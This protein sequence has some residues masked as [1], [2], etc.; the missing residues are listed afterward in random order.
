MSELDEI[1]GASAGIRELRRRIEELL[2]RQAHTPGQT[3]PP[4]LLPILIQGETGTGKTMLAQII[5]Q[6]GPRRASRFVDVDCGTIPADLLEAEL[7]GHQ[8]GS[9]TGA[10]RSRTGLFQTAHGGTLFLDEIGAL[11]LALQ[12]K[13]LKAIADRE[14][15]PVG[16]RRSEPADVAI[17]AATNDNLAVAARQG[18]FRLDLYHRLAGV[19][20]TL[21]PL[22]D[23]GADIITL[24]ERFLARACTTHGLPAKTLGE[25]ARAALCAYAWPGNIRELGYVMDR[26]AL[27]SDATTVTADALG[28]PMGE[29][30]AATSEAMCAR[31]LDA[32][33]R[34]SWNIT[35]TAAL[36]G[37]TRLTVRA[38]IKRCGLRPEGGIATAPALVTDTPTAEDAGET[39]MAPPAAVEPSAPSP[40]SAGATR[41]ERRRVTLLRVRLRASDDTSLSTTAR[42]IEGLFERVRVFGGQVED[43]SPRGFLA[44]FGLDPDE[45]APRRAAETALALRGGLRT[46]RTGE[47][48]PTEIAVV[49]AIHVSAMLV[50][51]LGGA[52]AIDGDAKLEAGRMLETLERSVGPGEIALSD[53]AVAFLDRRFEVTREA[54]AEG[55]IARL[56]GRAPD[57]LRLATTE[58]VGRHRELALLHGLLEHAVSGRGQIVSIVGAPGIGKSRLVREFVRSLTPTA[59]GVL[60]GR[61]T[62]LNASVPYSL[63][64]DVLRRAC[65]VE[66]ADGPDAVHVKVLNVLDRLGMSASPWAALVFNL[67]GSPTAGSA[68]APE[69]V[70]EHTFEALQQVLIAQQERGPL[71]LVLEDVHDIDRMSGELL[72]AVTGIVSGKRILLVGTARPSASPPWTG[73]V[74]AT[75]IALAPLGAADSRRVLMSA[76]VGRPLAEDTVSALVARGEGNPL[77]LEELARSVAPDAEPSLPR[78]PETL[79]DVLGMRVDRLPSS[80]RDVLHLAAVIGRDVP[81]ALLES[82]C[83]LPADIVGATLARLQTE[84]F[85]YATRL[86]PHAEYTFN[87][88]LTWQVAYDSMLDDVR[89]ELHARVVAAIERLYAARLTEHVERLAEH[90]LRARDWNLAITYARQAG[91]KAVARSAYHDAVRDFDTALDALARLPDTEA[92]R[93]LGVDL[94]LE[95]R[96]AL[97]ALG[98][99]GRVRERLDEA[100][101]LARTLADE[102][103]LGRVRAYQTSYYRQIGDHPRA[104]EAGQHA[105]RIGEERGNLALR[106]TG[107]IYLGH[108]HYDVGDY[109]KA[110]DLFSAVVAAVGDEHRLERF[111]LPYVVAVHARTWLA[112]SL[113]ERGEFD[114]ALAHARGALAI[115]EATDHPTTLTSALM[116]LGRVLHRAGRVPEA[117]PILERAMELARANRIQLLLPTIAESLGLSCSELGRV[118][119]GVKLLEEAMHVHEGTRGTAGLACRA[120]SLSRG[121]LRAGRVAD[122]MRVGQHGLAL[123]DKHGERGHRAYALEAL[124]TAAMVIV[125]PDVAAAERWRLEAIHLA[126]ELEAGPLLARCRASSELDQ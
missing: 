96:G 17:I 8:K 116:G 123:A 39:V 121:Y 13:F 2:R 126:E 122:A 109:R 61:C 62:P 44:V 107:G 58:F 60:Q 4:R 21:P 37:I 16:A 85:L 56:V 125:P 27:A 94:R 6:A 65:G 45:D 26:A 81:Q 114:A 3:G 30:E 18:R 14:V 87:H 80:T 34:T 15:R 113:G 106:V 105:L 77:F 102:L 83:P 38:R 76:L 110:T 12:A 117:V 57:D 82:A 40:A 84:E 115:A 52:P 46:T 67:I 120:A 29:P 36:L 103:R 93:T 66:E 55:V 88:A 68:P 108:V 95:V 48:A 63:V 99:F 89:A 32:L 98:E 41:W 35:K 49:A 24:A 51:V 5:H 33:T 54:T 71:V 92:T 25:D 75:Q 101:T 9:F 69:V 28:L 104:L 7:F 100:E 91:Q 23:R 97:T 119:E 20:L 59:T 112:L 74:S 73:R 10:D 42:L 90:A 78:V 1:V 11:P 79:R 111:G 31:L 118:E 86:G 64:L 124:A 22:R 53:A 43:I 47:D 19:T 50:T 72:T 70:R